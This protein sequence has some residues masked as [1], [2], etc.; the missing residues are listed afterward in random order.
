[1]NSFLA[2]AL[3]DGDVYSSAGLEL[4][5]WNIESKNLLWNVLWNMMILV[6]FVVFTVFEG[7]EHGGDDDS[8]IKNCFDL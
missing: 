1:M 2:L 6:Y 5:Q 7:K 3:N 8:T 4:T